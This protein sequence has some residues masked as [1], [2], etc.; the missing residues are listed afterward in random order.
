[1]PIDAAHK[2][3][4]Q[5]FEA[6]FGIP[7]LVAILL[8]FVAPLALPRGWQTPAVIGGVALGIAGVTLIV[9]ARRE[10]A[11][12]R[13]PTDPGM[14]TSR[15]VTTGVLSISRNPLFFGGVCLLAGI[16]LVFN[17]VWALVLLLPALVACHAILI[18]PEERYLAAKFGEEYSGYAAT[19]RRWVGRRQPTTQR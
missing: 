13:Q 5:T 2:A 16:A 7:F 17:L 6:V 3:W 9:L 18:A 8:H 19:V 11:Q 1:M 15:I 12:H 10:L 14:P 4:W